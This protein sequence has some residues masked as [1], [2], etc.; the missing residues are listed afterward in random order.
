MTIARVAKHAGT[1]SANIHYHFGSK[2]AL[3]TAMGEYALERYADVARDALARASAVDG[4]I[5]YSAGL[6]DLTLVAPGHSGVFVAIALGRI[7][8]DLPP[9]SERD[10]VLRQLLE[11]A[12]ASGEVGELNVDV[13]AAMISGGIDAVVARGMG[14]R[15]AVVESRSAMLRAISS[16]LGLATDSGVAVGAWGGEVR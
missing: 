1:S 3:L 9:M 15:P 6:F 7:E 4:I 12:V 2:A 16:L 11:S 14:D 10:S 8:I 5:A 13:I